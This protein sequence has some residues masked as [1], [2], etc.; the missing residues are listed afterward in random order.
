MH[1][2][3]WGPTILEFGKPFNLQKFTNN[4]WKDAIGDMAFESIGYSLHPDKTYTQEIDLSRWDLEPGKYRIIKSFGAQN[5]DLEATLGV[6]FEI[7]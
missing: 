3:N 7:E 6:E 4:N 1:V 2:D 5:T